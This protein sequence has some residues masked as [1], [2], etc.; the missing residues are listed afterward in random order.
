MPLVSQGAGLFRGTAPWYTQFRRGYPP[1]VIE[2]LRQRAG[3]TDASRVLDLGCGTG[4]LALEFA[5]LVDYV[6]GV[7][8]DEEML[9]FAA[10]TATERNIANCDWVHSPAEI[11][12]FEPG[13]FDLVVIGSAF[14]W[15]DRRA[16]ADRVHDVLVS[17]GLLAVLGNPTA[18]SEVTRRE[19]IGKVIAEVQDRWFDAADFPQA[20]P[21]EIRHESVLAASRF[22]GAEVLHH[23]TSEDWDVD[24]FI[25]FLRS[26]S[27]RP[28]QLLGERFD[29]FA[30]DLRRAILGVLPDGRWTVEA[31]VEIILA[32]RH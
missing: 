21:M 17:N 16:V 12:S 8:V 18:L 31:N 1:A 26:T 28:D 29:V 32:V 22:G 15:M 23:P 10:A 13:S 2:L 24:R 14:H 20:S 3:L 11:V 5:P 9:A 4:Q 27:L 25:G 7:D 6:V 30:D 19:G